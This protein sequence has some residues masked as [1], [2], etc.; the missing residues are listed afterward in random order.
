MG[1]FVKI[2]AAWIVQA[3]VK[4][5]HTL[6]GTEIN[7]ELKILYSRLF[8]GALEMKSLDLTQN[9]WWNYHTLS[10]SSSLQIL[11]FQ[12]KY[13]SQISG[14]HEMKLLSHPGDLF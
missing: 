8:L 9:L 11:L 5:R 7:S 2:N 13:L 1:N 3:Q 14:S 10:K 12:A 6:T 4:L